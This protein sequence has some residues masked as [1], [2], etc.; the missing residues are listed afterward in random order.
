MITVTQIGRVFV[1]ATRFLNP[2]WVEV[3]A[4][5]IRHDRIFGLAEA[6]DRFVTTERHG[7]FFP[8][9]FHYESNG[10]RLRLEMPD[11]EVMEGYA[12]AIGRRWEHDH[13]GI[14]RIPIGEVEGPWSSAISA[15]AGRPIRLVRCLGQASALDVM[16]ITFVTTGSLQRLGRELGGPM[17]AARFRPGFVFD[18]NQE[19]VED[20]WDGRLLRVGDVTLR[21]RTPVPRCSIPGLDPTHGV[22]DLDVMK[23]L[24]RY[25]PKQAYPGQPP[26]SAVTPGFATYAE[27]LEPGIVRV[28]DR[29]ELVP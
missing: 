22:R 3:D 17:E 27:V 12:G 7:D 23:G 9:T 10:D 4:D 24:I 6:D 20:G 13:H 2:D 25:R 19:H 15:F 11:G 1:K 16:P 28:G 14:R 18:N 8:L 5:G 21:V 29:V 26:E